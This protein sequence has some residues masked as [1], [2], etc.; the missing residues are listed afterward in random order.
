MTVRTCLDD[1][2][3]AK[4]SSAIQ[5][6]LTR[7]GRPAKDTRKFVEAV[8]WIHRTGVPWR[9]LPCEFGSWQTVFTRFDRW[10]KRGVWRKIFQVLRTDVDDE[11]HTIDATINRAHQH[12]AGGKGGPKNKRLA[13]PWGEL[14]RKFILS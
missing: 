5:A 10:S 2:Q 3:W 7:R 11:W 13:G 1:R 9:D 12:S 8:F 6:S 14:Q 4:F